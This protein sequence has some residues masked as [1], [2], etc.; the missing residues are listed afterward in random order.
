MAFHRVNVF[1]GDVLKS[2]RWAGSWSRC[3][4]S[5]PAS[6][7]SSSRLPL[8]STRPSVTSVAFTRWRHPYTRL[9]THLST[10]KE[11]K[12]E[13]AWCSWLSWHL[14]S[15]PARL[16]HVGWNR[17][18]SWELRYT[19]GRSLLQRLKLVRYTILSDT[20]HRAVSPRQL[21]LLYPRPQ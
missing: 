21:N 18:F 4:G 15:S 1:D 7:P 5:Q 9:I 2:N 6:H 19:F 3:T 16:I 13:S 10:Q 14:C 12:A 20:D 11:W 8:L 17:R